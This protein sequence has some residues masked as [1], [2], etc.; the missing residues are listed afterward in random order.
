[1]LLVCNNAARMRLMFSLA[2]FPWISKT[3]GST[4]VVAACTNYRYQLHNNH[5]LC[6]HAVA[7]DNN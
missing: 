3:L 7:N 4:N 6:H 2:L 5:S 1:M